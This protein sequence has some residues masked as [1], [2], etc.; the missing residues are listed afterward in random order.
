MAP[1]EQV[2]GSAVSPFR[3]GKAKDVSFTSCF[4]C[5]TL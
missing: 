3:Y 2:M 5:S 1:S 4:F